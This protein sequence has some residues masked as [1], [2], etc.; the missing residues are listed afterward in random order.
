MHIYRDF[1]FNRRASLPKYK[2]TYPKHLKSE[3][4]DLGN[5]YNT[6]AHDIIGE[7]MWKEMKTGRLNWS[8]IDD[9]YFKI[10]EFLGEQLETYDPD[11]EKKLEIILKKEE[12]ILDEEP[13][14]LKRKKK[15]DR[16]IKIKDH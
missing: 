6:L 10:A 8:M 5:F 11:E 9:R 15:R 3:G 7:K 2:K 14:K 16:R 4:T 1:D 12:I 13:T